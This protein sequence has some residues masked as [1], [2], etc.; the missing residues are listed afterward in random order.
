MQSPKFNVTS[1]T[2]GLGFAVILVNTGVLFTW[3]DNLKGQL[4]LGDYVARIEP[5][6]LERLAKTEKIIEVS[7]GLKHVIARTSLGKVYCWGWG[8]RGQLGFGIN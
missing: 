5:T 4:G 1:I 2:Q 3:G 6:L 8:E 7:A